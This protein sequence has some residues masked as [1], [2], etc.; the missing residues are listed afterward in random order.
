[1]TTQQ[2][3]I[4]IASALLSA[5]AKSIFD[6]IL[7]VYIPDKSKLISYMRKLLLFSMGYAFPV[8][9]II[10]LMVTNKTVDKFFVLGMLLNFSAVMLNMT[11]DYVHYWVGYFSNSRLESAKRE[12]EMV[13]KMIEDAKKRMANY[14]IDSGK[15]SDNT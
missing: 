15:K 9:A 4:I 8:C 3:V 7:G 14:E 12:H 11:M 2:I 1:M 13:S 5:F 6:K 10:F